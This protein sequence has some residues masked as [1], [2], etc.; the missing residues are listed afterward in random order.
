M[1]HCPTA[2]A[3]PLCHEVSQLKLVC[4]TASNNYCV[5]LTG[6]FPLLLYRSVARYDYTHAIPTSDESEFKGQ[7]VSKDRRVSVICR[8]IPN[9]ITKA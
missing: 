9:N 2:K 5:I 4:I 3:I 7:T 1:D 6:M 8:T